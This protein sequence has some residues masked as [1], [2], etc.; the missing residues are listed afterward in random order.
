MPGLSRILLLGE[1]FKQKQQTRSKTEL[2]CF[3][4]LWWWAMPRSTA[5][6]KAFKPLLPT[7]SFFKD[8]A[9]EALG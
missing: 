5:T 8:A 6:Y 2:W 1:A 3:C 9:P 7:S 4:G